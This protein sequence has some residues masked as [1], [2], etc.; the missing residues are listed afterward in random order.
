MSIYTILWRKDGE[1]RWDRIGKDY[2]FDFLRLNNLLDNEDAMIYGPENDYKTALQ[3]VEK[4]LSM[5]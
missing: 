4:G 3:L 5:L 1:D 2:L